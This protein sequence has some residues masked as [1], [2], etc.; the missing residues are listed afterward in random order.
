MQSDSWDTN[1]Q[2]EG[3]DEGD[4]VKSDGRTIFIASGSTVRLVS[5]DGAGSRELSRIETSELAVANTD[6]TVQGAVSDLMLHGTTLVALVTD[7]TPRLEA[8]TPNHRPFGFT[9]YLARETKALVYDVSD[10]AA[11]RFLTWLGQSGAPSPRD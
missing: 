1:V 8:G 6:G 9:P 7:F 11:P 3:I 2:V 5:A 10:P 4:L